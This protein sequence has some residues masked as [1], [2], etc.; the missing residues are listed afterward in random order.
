MGRGKAFHNKKKGHAQKPPQGAIIEKEVDEHHL[1]D[2]ASLV[3]IE[4]YK[5]SLRKG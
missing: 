5:N 3:E 1:E 2:E 4:T